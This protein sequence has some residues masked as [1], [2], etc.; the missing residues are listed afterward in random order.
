MIRRLPIR[1]VPTDGS[2]LLSRL[3]HLRLGKI[4]MLIMLCKDD[5]H[6]CYTCLTMQFI[7]ISKEE[8]EAVAEFIKRRGRVAISE[9][10]AKSN[11]FIDLEARASTVSTQTPCKHC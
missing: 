8:M 4:T 1:N 9:L 11:T 3:S 6:S 10:A 2:A 5:V 7:Y